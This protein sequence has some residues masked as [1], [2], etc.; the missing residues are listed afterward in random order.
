M[1][2]TCLGCLDHNNACFSNV[3]HACP[4][5]THDCDC[6]RMNGIEDAMVTSGGRVFRGWGLSWM[7]YHGA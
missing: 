3:I 7:T 6:V 1:E 5:D 4:M 2:R